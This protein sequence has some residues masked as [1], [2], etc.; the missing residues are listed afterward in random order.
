MGVVFCVNAQHLVD[1][2]RVD[3]LKFTAVVLADSLQ[4][5]NDALLQVSRPAQHRCRVVRHANGDLYV[6]ESKYNGPSPQ[7]S[8]SGG[9]T[10]KDCFGPRSTKNHNDSGSKLVDSA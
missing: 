5:F 10:V 9:P 3:Q 6:R 4:V 8:D 1:G 7:S 2:V